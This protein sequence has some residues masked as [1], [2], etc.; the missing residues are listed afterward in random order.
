[1]RHPITLD[2][3]HMLGSMLA[4]ANLR[5]AWLGLACRVALLLLVWGLSGCA[6]LPLARDAAESTATQ[7]VQHTLLA[8]IAAGSDPAP[9]P[10]RSGFRLLPS[11]EQALD[12]RL[13]LIA[14]TER[15][16][17][18]QYYQVAHDDTGLRL[19]RA[20]RDAG[21][22]GVRVRLLID[23]L[24]A[25]GQDL[26]LAG[27]AAQPN[28]QV[29][30]FN[31]LPVRDAGFGT[32][33]AL[34]LH[35]FSRINRRMHNKLFVA[36]NS[37]S[38]SG[39]RNIADAYFGRS[40]PSNFIDLDVLA[41]G[42]VV[43]QQSQVFDRFWNSPQAW[44]VQQLADT[45]PAQP[46]RTAA[47]LRDAFDL[48][49]QPLQPDTPVTHPDEL[50]QT[51]VA[52]QLANGRLQLHYGQARVLADAP[53]KAAALAAE[54]GS[55]GE[56]ARAHRTLLQDARHEVLVTSPY[57]VPG[58]REMAALQVATQRQVQFSVITN[59]LSTTDEPLVH[60]GYARYR[61]ALLKM[62]V[63]LYELM[64]SLTGAAEHHDEAHD[65]TR[66]AATGSLGRLH[67]K[68]A[69][70]DR[71]W[72][73]I[74]S[75]NMDRRSALTNTEAGLIIDSPELC[76]QVRATLQNARM[77]GSYRLRLQ[78]AEEG[79]ERIVWVK[80]DVAAEV[81]Q[82]EEPQSGAIRRIGLWLM[83]GVVGE[84]ML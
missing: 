15:T 14:M 79:T 36:D 25:A 28:V 65:R 55:D 9:A 35:E 32:R 50:G 67:A 78:R 75:M 22:R 69:V 39:G 2:A 29:R 81:V 74:G 63:K 51:S 44:P 38:I 68:L 33:I 17:D 12:A 54:A 61:H 80:G 6:R 71:R 1:M 77:P 5:Q 43:A 45:N 24:Y 73:Y 82:G 58:E 18:L 21:Q 13:A 49:V 62:G 34:S 53:T 59:S 7:D 20:L 64:P 42:A 48:R 10:G 72:L 11:G 41:T 23:D 30:L 37:I 56:V 19:L 4:T 84:G 16:L 57:V 66:R 26:M 8:Q 52:S 83:L 47:A 70:V 27:L 40:E 76:E 3:W 60:A 31:P 46:A